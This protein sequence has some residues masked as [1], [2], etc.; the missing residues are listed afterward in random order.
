[1][2]VG[3]VVSSGEV[4]RTFEV[5]S[6]AVLAALDPGEVL[7]REV[8][9]DPEERLLEAV[10]HDT[11][12]LA[13]HAEGVTMRR[14]TGGPD[15]GWHVKLPPVGD[16]REEIQAPLAPEAPVELLAL[17]RAFTR[18]RPVQPVARLRTHR[19]AWRAVT[20]GGGLV[21]ELVVDAVTACRSGDREELAWTEIEVELGPAAPAGFLDV[22]TE[23]LAARGIHRS[24][25]PSKVARVLGER[26]VSVLPAPDGSAA[27]V[28]LE[29]L[30]GQARS[31]RRWDPL[32]RLDREDAVHQ[33]RVAARRIRSVLQSF[34]RV[35]HRARTRTLTGELRWLA[36]ELAPAR[37][38]EVMHARLDELLAE[39][40]HELVLGPVHAELAA[41]F[42]RRAAAARDRALA[43]LDGTR[44][45][46]LLAAL[47]ALLAEPPLARRA[48]DDA[49]HVLPG[50]VARARRRVDA[51]IAAAR[52]IAPG[53]ELD[54]DLH[55]AR[56]AAKRLRYA[57]EAARPVLDDSA[58]K[59][60]RR[61]AARQEQLGVHQDTVVTRATLLELAAGE[62]AHGFTLGVMY[63]AEVALARRTEAAVAAGA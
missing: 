61:M 14:R 30:R 40:P 7:G 28:V 31:L 53:A 3:A 38:T 34:R 22:V 39:V 9:V 46:A 60:I 52:G 2:A 42:A 56:K 10:Y 36:G 47:D 23:R 27:A 59:G 21:A 49:D 44:Y 25:T 16:R 55:E 58:R 50:E 43:A 20:G 1:M 54:T 45:L 62:V 11:A 17:V 51:A 37:D 8:P 33:M 63:A 35:L 13:L 29:Y 19:R 18:G 48:L 5:A 24:A 6:V 26:P 12:D 41:A 32:V 15:E 57:S 4:E